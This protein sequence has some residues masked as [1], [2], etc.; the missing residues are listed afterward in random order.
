MP[1]VVPPLLQG[2]D[3]SQWSPP[4]AAAHGDRPIKLKLSFSAEDEGGSGCKR[5]AT[6]S[7]SSTDDD[8]SGGGSRDSRGTEVSSAGIFRCGNASVL[9]TVKT[10]L[11]SVAACSEDGYRNTSALMLPSRVSAPVLLASQMQSVPELQQAG[12]HLNKV[13]AARCPLYS[14]FVCCRASSSQVD[15]SAVVLVTRNLRLR[16]DSAAASGSELSSR[17]HAAGTIADAGRQPSSATPCSTLRSDAAFASPEAP[18]GASPKAAGTDA[19]RVAEV[20]APAPVAQLS[21]QDWAAA[22]RQGRSF[23]N[24]LARPPLPL[25]PPGELLLLLISDEH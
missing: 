6:A 18:E 14:L 23:K 9:E 10:C 25:T 16:C 4:G 21:L 20:A 17:S 11:T 2:R 19:D 1:R 3:G 15:R 5:K 12:P 13:I 22:L 24:P 8:E 7:P